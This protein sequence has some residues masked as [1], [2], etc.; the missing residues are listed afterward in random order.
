MGLQSNN[1]TSNLTILKAVSRNAEKEN[2]DPFFSVTRKVNGVWTLSDEKASKVSGKLI[3]FELKEETWKDVAYMTYKLYLADGD[4]VFLVDLRGG[5]TSRS[6]FNALLGIEN[7]GKTYEIS[8]YANKKGYPAFSVWCDGVMV[9]WKF[10]M[11][12]IPEPEVITR[13]GKEEKDWFKVEV[14]FDEQLTEW[15]KSI[16]ENKNNGNS[17]NCPANVGVGASSSQGDLSADDIVSEDGDD[18]VPF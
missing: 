2:I 10:S 3:R 18:D 5:M 17:A 6:L 14:F 9:P 12:E 16:P 7:F 8:Y 11:D 1:Q 4:E 15:S 13:R